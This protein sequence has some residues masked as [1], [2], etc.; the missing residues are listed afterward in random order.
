MNREILC[1]PFDGDDLKSAASD[2]TK[3]TASLLGVGLELYGGGQSQ[4]EPANGN[5]NAPSAQQRPQVDRLTAR[6]LAAIHGAARRANVSRDQLVALVHRA[7]KNQLEALTKR[8]A[9]DLISELT[10]SNGSGR[11]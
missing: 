3:K 2:A 1:K 11:M 10:G 4:A 7:G 8:E 5:V 9:S 6:Q